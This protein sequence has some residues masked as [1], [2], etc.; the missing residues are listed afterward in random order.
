M[1]KVYVFAAVAAALGA[2]SAAHADLFSSINSFAVYDRW[3]GDYPN[4]VPVVT[5]GGLPSIRFQE[6]GYVTSQGFSTRNIGFLAVDGA[7]FQF[8]PNQGFRVDT[9][10]TIN[11]NSFAT[12][13]GFTLGTAPNL[14]SSAGANT[15]DFHIRVP[16][17]EIAA[18]GGTN[19]FFANNNPFNGGNTHPWPAIT[20]GVTYHMTMIYNTSPGGSSMNFGVNGVFTGDLAMGDPTILAGTYVGVFAQGPNNFPLSP[21]YTKDVIYTNTTIAIPAPATAGVLAMS[22]LVALRRRRR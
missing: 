11:S 7:P 16:D 2:T 8:N 9:D 15:G 5:N 22:G 20:T 21:G 12:E 10:V 17:G 18:F 6:S 19:P 4:S 3:F 1:S 14:P 13:A